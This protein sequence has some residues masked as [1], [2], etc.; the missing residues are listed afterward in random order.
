M[1]IPDRLGRPLPAFHAP[2]R[3]KP[4]SEVVLNDPGR[5]ALDARNRP[6][7]SDDDP[8][9]VDKDPPERR[10]APRRRRSD[11]D[12]E[13]EP[14][15]DLE[16]ILERE[17][18]D[19]TPTQVT[20]KAVDQMERR[21]AAPSA[22]Q[23]QGPAVPVYQA[24]RLELSA[25]TIRQ[26]QNADRHAQAQSDAARRPRRPRP[27]AEATAIPDAS[28]P[29]RSPSPPPV[30]GFV[31]HSGSQAAMPASQAATPV[32]GFVPTPTRSPPPVPGFVPKPAAREKR[33][34][35]SLPDRS[36][37]PK[38]PAMSNLPPPPPLPGPAP[39]R[40][41]GLDDTQ[42]RL[43]RPNPPPKPRPMP[44]REELRESIVSGV[45]TLPEGGLRKDHP[46]DELI[47]LFKAF[48]LDP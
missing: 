23:S 33:R 43:R 42:P 16:A 2:G 18:A 34:P 24:E 48:D 11:A 29:T 10:R 7:V 17:L 5:A 25:E 41:P 37:P 32:P 12:P 30:P 4:S 35:P 44:T 1:K 47:G 38:W 46:Q 21:P 20:A 15:V 27:E 39:A 9:R 19:D 13:T 28:E 45:T 14:E 3:Q 36:A 22:R 40:H 26:R 8:L 6:A 31:P